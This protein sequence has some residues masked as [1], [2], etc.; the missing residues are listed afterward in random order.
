MLGRQRVGQALNRLGFEISEM[1]SRLKGCGERVELKF[2]L[3]KMFPINATSLK[4]VQYTRRLQQLLVLAKSGDTGARA[5][6]DALLHKHHL[7]EDDIPPVRPRGRPRGAN[8]ELQE[9]FYPLV[10]T[11]DPNVTQRTKSNAYFETSALGTL[12][13][14][15]ISPSAEN[16]KRWAWLLRPDGNN[17]THH[18]K[19]I[20]SAL[21]RVSDYGEVREVF[22]DRLCELK[23]RAKDAIRLL[24]D[25]KVRIYLIG[26]RE[27]VNTDAKVLADAARKACGD[28]GT[29]IVD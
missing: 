7:T 19:T 18:R 6:L 14:E 13:G 23:P 12:F 10:G 2:D 22:A 4:F 20:L 16:L 8:R 1:S 17:V 5:T 29:S 24:H 15:T 28:S 3:W 26:T 11:L 27:L 9:F 21:G 25:W